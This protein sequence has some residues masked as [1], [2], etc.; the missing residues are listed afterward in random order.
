MAKTVG[1]IIEG[2]S[3][4]YFVR[5]SDSITK[6]C[7]YMCE[8]KVGA[9]AVQ[10]DNGHCCGVFSERDLLNRVVVRGVD[11]NRTSVSEVM[12]PDLVT[13][14]PKE[15]C[16]V[17]AERMKDRETRHLLVVEGKRYLGMI[18]QSDLTRTFLDEVSEERDLLKHYAFP[19]LPG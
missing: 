15:T 1:E 13:A 16:L 6:A 11:P 7:E 9:V 14:R 8:R 18:T 5:T 12:S 4:F 3:D 2:R 19:E 10:D 17:A